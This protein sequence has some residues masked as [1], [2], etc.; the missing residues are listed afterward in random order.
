MIRCSDVMTNETLSCLPGDSVEQVAQLLGL[1]GIGPVLVV[2]DHQTRKLAGI[3]TDR[4]LV[5]KILAEGRDSKTT[6]VAEVMTAGVVTVR[7]NDDVQKALDT[8]IDQQLRRVPVVDSESRIVGMVALTDVAQDPSVPQETTA[9][10]K[11]IHQAASA[12]Q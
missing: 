4:D 10:V 1:R 11:V 7:D 9:L 12:A 3:V 5:Q 8:M 6:L 2:E